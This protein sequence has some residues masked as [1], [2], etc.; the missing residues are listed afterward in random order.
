MRIVAR[1]RRD[2]PHV[3]IIASLLAA[4]QPM[5]S[6]RGPVRGP[7]MAPAAGRCPSVVRVYPGD[8]LYA[9]ARR[10]DVSVRD[11]IEANALRPP[12]MLEPGTT[13]RMPGSGAVYTVAK[14]DTLSVLA[15]RFGVDFGTLA[16]LNGKQPPYTIFVGETL[17]VP[18]AHAPKPATET[19]ALASPNAGRIEPSGRPG[20][21]LST[22]S[23]T[24][25]EPSR[26]RPSPAPQT[27][28]PQPSPPDLPPEPAALAGRGFAWPIKGEVV[29]E[30]GPIAKG[31]HNDGL[32]IAAPK[33][34]GVQAAENGVVVYSGNEL[35]GFG[36][37]L[38]VKHADGWMTAY[39][40]NDKLLVKKGET[41]TRGQT[42][43]TVG[44]TGNV[45][46]PQLHFEIRKGT[47][48]VDPRKYLAQGAV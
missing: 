26:P 45:D 19:I 30:F 39:A 38:L 23:P 6:E 47:E 40:H 29:S 46:S 7:G 15:R 16:R 28:S 33:G 37:L 34:T 12:Y 17:K 10:C 48:A 20:P 13:I 41:V 21:A 25:T 11:L 9:V 27:A 42:I 14:G 35:K 8:T 4:C 1:M 43:A 2:L 3:V 5:W 22:P 44:A 24:V 18:G 36:N 32:N 31:Q